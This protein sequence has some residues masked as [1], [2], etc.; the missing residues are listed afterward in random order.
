MT[1]ISFC[2]LLKLPLNVKYL[3]NDLIFLYTEY[4]L[5]LWETLF[6]IVQYLDYY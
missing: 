5:I 1:S 6:T 4:I 2:N 3:T